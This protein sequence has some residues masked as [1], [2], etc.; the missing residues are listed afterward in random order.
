[1]FEKR[2]RT[3]IAGGE[4]FGDRLARAA[5]MARQQQRTGDIGQMTDTVPPVPRQRQGAA[6]NGDT[7]SVIEAVKPPSP[8]DGLEVVG[9]V[10]EDDRLIKVYGRPEYQA[11]APADAV[12]SEPLAEPEAVKTDDSTESADKEARRPAGRRMAARSAVT[13]LALMGL[14]AVSIQGT[15]YSSRPAPAKPAPAPSPQEPSAGSSPSPANQPSVAQSP[16][17]ASPAAPVAVNFKVDGSKWKECVPV[18]EQATVNATAISSWDIPTSNGKVKLELPR[19]PVTAGAVLKLQLCPGPESA[20][21]AVEQNNRTKLRIDWGK[22]LPSVQFDEKSAKL[23]NPLAS[24]SPAAKEAILLGVPNA[25]DRSLG[26]FAAEAPNVAKAMRVLS[27]QESEK[28]NKCGKVL[29][30]M[31]RAAILSEVVPKVLQGNGLTPLSISLIETID[32]NRLPSWSS[33]YAGQTGW[34][35]NDPGRPFELQPVSSGCAVQKKTI[36][37]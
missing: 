1:M 10:V 24:L 9:M 28:A 33:A 22:I 31:A 30:D 14:A 12:Y 29:D 25:T 17:A 18:G 34:L 26:V 16:E 15:S 6:V 27:V 5:E 4:S 23:I 20:F 2:Q 21:S 3:T 19:N 32:T 11:D 13:M 8:F 36:Y 37:Q 7:A 35:A